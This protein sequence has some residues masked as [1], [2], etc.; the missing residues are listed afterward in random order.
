M[1]AVLP[2]VAGVDGSPTS[3]DAAVWAAHAAKRRGLPLLLVSVTPITPGVMGVLVPIPQEF[4]DD[5][6]QLTT[7]VLVDAASRVHAEFGDDA[8]EIDTKVLTGIPAAEMLEYSKKAA[9]MVTGTRGLGDLTAGVV[10]SVSSALIGHTQ[11]P[12]VV[13]HRR[14][15]QADTSAGPVVVG[16]D[17]SDN[18]V[19]ALAA[20][21]EEAS[22]RSVE[23]I[24]V[25]AFSDVLMDS[26]FEDSWASIE[27]SERAVLSEH[28]AGYAEQY[29]D[30]MVTPV[31]SKV[32]PVNALLEKAEGA[33]LIVVGSRGRG[34]YMGM[35]LGSTS[36]AIVHTAECPVMIVRH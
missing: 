22:L 14:E 25:H 18:S 1:S 33:S 27:D 35:L 5:Q 8:I 7:R 9:L 16:V 26:M 31:V 21:F 32:R 4:Y 29:P 19:P 34:G 24:A 15:P 13:V 12:V 30:V 10:G 23:L 3:E 2:V 36:R 20:A 11:C 17:G 28:L 6:H